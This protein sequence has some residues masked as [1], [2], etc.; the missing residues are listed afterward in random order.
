MVGVHIYACSGADNT[1]TRSLEV[2]IYCGI[3][4]LKTLSQFISPMSFHSALIEQD[5]GHAAVQRSPPFPSV[6]RGNTFSSE[7]LHEI[8]KSNQIKFDSILVFVLLQY[9]IFFP[10][11]T[12][13]F[14]LA[15]KF[16]SAFIAVSSEW[17]TVSIEDI[18]FEF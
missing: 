18:L 9:M 16:N 15:Q 8:I 5:L 4:L 14:V 2:S 1:Y 12:S 10:L 13:F 7:H 11:N 17:V 3:C 6:Y